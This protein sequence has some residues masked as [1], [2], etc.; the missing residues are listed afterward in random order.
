MKFEIETLLLR[1]LF[2]A[3]VLI[4]VMTVGNMLLL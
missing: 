1:S 2:G 4:S 3:C